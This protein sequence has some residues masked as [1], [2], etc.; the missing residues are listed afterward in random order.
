MERDIAEV[1]RLW[2]G[3]QRLNCSRDT[4][5]ELILFDVMHI[6]GLFEESPSYS[7]WS[8]TAV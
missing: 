2:H 8:F 3:L 7:K 1:A 5:A 6:D 4:G